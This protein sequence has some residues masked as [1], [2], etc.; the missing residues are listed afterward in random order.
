MR[1]TR[2]LEP[3]DDQSFL[4]VKLW[5]IAPALRILQPKLGVEGRDV[6]PS[7]CRHQLGSAGCAQESSPGKGI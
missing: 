7:A 4:C 3:C 6:E 2:F 5:K 1:N